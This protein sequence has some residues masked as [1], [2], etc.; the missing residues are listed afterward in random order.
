MKYE[1][2]EYEARYTQLSNDDLIQLYLDGDLVEE[3]SSALIDE[4]KRRGCVLP[5]KIEVDQ[6]KIIKGKSTEKE[7]RAISNT[8]IFCILLFFYFFY[9]NGGYE[10]VRDNLFPEYS[11][12]KYLEKG[13]VFAQKGD[14][15]KALELYRKAVECSPNNSDTYLAIGTTYVLLNRLTEAVDYFKRA[16]ELKPD[17]GYAYV[18][19]SGVYYKLKDYEMA[20]L[21]AEESLSIFK[22]DRDKK[23]VEK[24]EFILQ[25]IEKERDNILQK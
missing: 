6:Y 12:N 18:L 2:E 21:Y 11:A 15:N 24:A 19:L 5:N 23:N 3:A 4:I 1:K 10:H 17:S 13:V 9:Q 16:I 20:S 14:H 25:Q 8:I 7:K 22:S